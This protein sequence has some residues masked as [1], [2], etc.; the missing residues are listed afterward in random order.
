MPLYEFNAVKITGETVSGRFNASD[1]TEI[2]QMIREKQYYP[3]SVKEITTGKE[4]GSFSFGKKV[5]VKDL[6]IFCRQFHT[7]LLAG[8]TIVQCLDILREQTEHKYFRET[9]GQ[10]YE[11]VQKGSTFAEALRNHPDAFPEILISMV[12]AGEVSG[13]LDSIMEKMADNFEKENKIVRKVKGALIYPIV[14]SIVA[15]GVVIFLLTVVMPTFI[16]MFQSSGVE[17]PAPTRILL[18][19]SSFL[20]SFWYILLLVIIAAV[21]LI[22]RYIKTDEGRYAFDRLKLQLPVVG[23]TMRKLATSRFTRTTSTLMASGIPLLQAMSIVSKVVGNRVVAD[24]LMNVREELRKGI[25]LAGPIKRMGVFPPM[26][27]S[28]IRIG[29]ESGSLD[30]ILQKTADFYDEEVEA[31]LQRM[32]AM[33]EPLLIVFMGGMIGFIVIAMAMPMFDMAKTV[34]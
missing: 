1:R 32:V 5:R 20:R 13:R 4:L 29:E 21:Y 7:M 31:A 22:R 23:M 27:D 15:V 12:E 10:V 6:A 16:G 34:K 11:E 33:M 28:M 18:A 26:V 24:G 30:G 19:I 14:L 25:D 2:L 8:I 17:L 9:I 3:V